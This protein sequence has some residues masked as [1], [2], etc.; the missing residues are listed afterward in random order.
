MWEAGL[1]MAAHLHVAVFGPASWILYC[2]H[3]GT[4][5]TLL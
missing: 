2:S 1:G 3:I 5:V 4:V